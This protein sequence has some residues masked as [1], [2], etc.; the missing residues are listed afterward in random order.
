MINVQTELNVVL[1]AINAAAHRIRRDFFEIEK[2]QIS[3]KGTSDFVTNADL[4]V[5][6]SL[7][8]SLQ[9]QRPKYS[10]L[11]EES[12]YIDSIEKPMR[13]QEY[14]WV[15]DPIDGTFNFMHAIPFFCISIALLEK[16]QGSIKPILGVVFNPMT[17]ETFWASDGHGAFLIDSNGRTRRVFASNITDFERMLCV[18]HDR[19][20]K[21]D[22]FDKQMADNI[23]TKGATIRIFGSSALELAYLADGRINML[24]QGNVK[25]WDYAAAALIVEEAGGKLMNLEH[26]EIDFTSQE[27]SLLAGNHKVLS[28]LKSEIND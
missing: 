4:K 10:I 28:K 11:T 22:G 12:G 19:C 3:K 21:K 2:L 17:N 24:I 7:I 9:K 1:R 18:I 23:R 6:K 16:K 13:G 14:Q 26:H 25:I 5:E 27:S 8:A 15:I 20:S